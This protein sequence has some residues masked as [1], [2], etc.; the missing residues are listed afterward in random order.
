MYIPGGAL[1][2]SE[3][4]EIALSTSHSG[5]FELPAGTVPVSFVYYVAP[6]GPFRKPVTLEIEHCCS[7]GMD[8]LKFAFAESS[9]K[10][11]P[12][13]FTCQD[14]GKFSGRSSYGQL[15]VS[16][17][18]MFTI[19][20]TVESDCRDTPSP[21]KSD[22]REERANVSH[23]PTTPSPTKSDGRGERANVSHSPTTPS[24][25]K[26]DGREERADVSHRPTTPSSV[27][28]DGREYRA[29]VFHQQRSKYACRVV[30][31]VTERL[32]ECLQVYMPGAY[33]G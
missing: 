23:R 2:E 19:L 9:S 28:S 18:S 14:G 33:E 13:K 12:Y 24:S 17:F 1:D 20:S 15:Q 4:R 29:Y 22:G 26:S 30:L 11:P 10:K 3:E 8:K 5:C 16:H 6:S 25:A 31:V 27:E 7:H 21:T 32:A